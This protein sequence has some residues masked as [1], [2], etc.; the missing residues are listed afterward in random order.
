[1]PE[2]PSLRSCSAQAQQFSGEVGEFLHT[3]DTKLKAGTGESFSLIWCEGLSTLAKNGLPP[4]ALEDLQNLGPVLGTSDAS[5]A[6]QTLW[7]HCSG[8]WSRP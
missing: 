5:G 7:A 1:M 4:F 6:E 2:Q 8:G 3:L